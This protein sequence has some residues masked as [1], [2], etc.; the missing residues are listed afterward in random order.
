MAIAAS[1]AKPMNWRGACLPVPLREMLTSA[2]ERIFSK[3]RSFSTVGFLHLGCLCIAV[4]RSISLI[5]I[6][7]LVTIEFTDGRHVDFVHDHAQ[8]AI[9]KFRRSG[10]SIFG[11]IDSCTP[12]FDYIDI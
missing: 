10:E 7:A 6:I 1:L 11:S 4:S 9:V 12:P 8:K 2:N 3:D 5:I